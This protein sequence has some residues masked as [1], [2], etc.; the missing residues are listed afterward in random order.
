[1]MASPFSNDGL[2]NPEAGAMTATEEPAFSLVTGRNGTF[3][4]YAGLGVKPPFPV[5][6]GLFI[7]LAVYAGCVV[8]YVYFTYWSSAPYV[9]AE[10]YAAASELLGLDDGR[11]CSREALTDAYQH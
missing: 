11:T 4:H 1:M 10:H 9:A 8:G 6:Y 2:S 7:V 3:G 5:P